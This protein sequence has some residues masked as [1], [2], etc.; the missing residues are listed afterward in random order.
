MPYRRR[1]VALG[2]LGLLAACRSPEPD[3]YTILPVP[4]TPR[5]G[6]PRGVSVR[7]VS[8][9][10]YL[11]RLQIVRTTEDYRLAVSGNDWWGESLEAMLTRVLVENL[12][13]RLPESSV[14][15]TGGAI[16]SPAEAA[17]EVNVQRLGLSGP[18]TLA[19]TA[20]V[21]VA[22]REAPRQDLVRTETLTSPVAGSDTPAFVAAAS[23]AVGSLADVL[24]GLLAAP[25]PR[26]RR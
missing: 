21:A 8:L 20:Q 23:A 14:F 26:G 22:N 24:A 3:L 16:S 1:R 25:A 12:A 13:Q 11:D 5:R 2:A 4:G 18:A 10:R 6:G 15:A 19:L 17:V 9:A 7:T